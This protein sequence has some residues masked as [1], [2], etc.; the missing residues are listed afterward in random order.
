M[1]GQAMS[2]IK[3][4]AFALALVAIIPMANCA[5]QGTR[6]QRHDDARR[7]RRTVRH[8]RREPR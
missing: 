3:K 1:R 8:A 2:V 5:T 7:R 6:R 4:L